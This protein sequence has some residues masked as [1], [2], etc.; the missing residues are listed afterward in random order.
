MVE[1]KKIN[2]VEDKKSLAGYVT[3]IFPWNKKEIKE[4]KEV[5][6]AKDVKQ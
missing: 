1:E 3:S 2:V 6:E 5:K 4:V